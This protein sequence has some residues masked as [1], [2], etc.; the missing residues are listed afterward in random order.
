MIS[1]FSFRRWTTPGSLAATLVTLFPL[2]YFFPAVRGRITLCPD[3]GLLFN[4]PLRT[5]AAAIFLDGNLPLWNPYMFG[6]MPLFAS[7][8]GGLLFPLNWFYLIF[9][10]A[11]ATNM[12]VISTY[13]LAALGAYLYARRA[14]ASI[15]GA[16]VTSL[17]WQSGGVLV[18]QLSHINIVQ[19]AAMLP[20]LLWAMERYVFTRSSIR[21]LLLSVVVALQVFV[22]HP[23]TFCYSLLLVSAYAVVMAVTERSKR[24]GY[25]KSLAYI[26]AG[27]T[28]AAV[29][30]VP[31]LE[32]LRNSLRNEVT[33]DFF[34]SFSMPRR[35]IET[36]FAPYV[37]GGGDGGLFRAPYFGPPFYAEYI[38][39]VGLLTLMLALVALLIKRDSRNLFWTAIAVIGLILALGGNAP[40]GIAKLV[41]H[42]PVLNLFRVPSRHVMEVNFAL[43]VLAGRGLTILTSS[44]N[45][46]RLQAGVAGAAL[47]VFLLTCMAV[48]LGR[49]GEFR[50]GR[51]AP[52]T[53]LRAPELFVPVV[54]AALSAVALWIVMRGRMRGRTGVLITVL[55]IDL[56]IWGYSSGWRTNTGPAPGSEYWGQPETV[57][58]LK[59]RAQQQGQPNRILTLPHTFHPDRAPVPPSVSRST[60]WVVW[61]QPNIY[62]MH[63]IDNAAG[64]DGFGFARHSRLAGDMKV[65]GE[66]TDPNRTLRGSSREIDVLNVRYLLAIRPQ[67]KAP[68]VV[69][70][71][72][73]ATQNYGGNMFA[74]VDL[75]LSYLTSGHHVSFAVP[76]VEVDRIALVTNLAWAQDVPDGELLARVKLK[77][78]D[79]RVIE[80]PFRAG[81]DTAEWSYDR[82]DIRARVGHRRATIADSYAVKD[83]SQGE[84]NAHNYVTTLKLPERVKI[85]G[86]EIALEDFG[87]WPGLSLKLQRLT[88]AGGANWYPIRAEWIQVSA[89][90]TEAPAV[91][92]NDQLLAPVDNRW[93]LMGQTPWVDIYENTRALPRVW[94]APNE[95]VT[96]EDQAL[97]TIRTGQ[98][99]NGDSWDPLKTVLVETPTGIGSTN[100]ELGD[101]HA[102]VIR[103][104]VNR[105]AVK[106]RAGGATMLVLS[107]NHYPGWR[108]YVDQ[109]PADLIRANYN[110][111]GVRLEPGVHAVEFVYRPNSVIVGAVVSLLTL[112]GLVGLIFFPRGQ[113]FHEPT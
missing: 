49:P 91:E 76:P 78:S 31:T 6:G 63:R 88:M 45:T 50:L 64:Y 83:A 33:Y 32:L 2:F 75:S 16:I 73:P 30:I 43:A 111:R 38:A 108:V 71:F 113:P 21:G 103:R 18:A 13:M 14:G 9:N 105:V 79:G 65:W 86:G 95:I 29:Q 93:Q 102:E 70:S 81:I 35:F 48:T 67:S 46:R 11:A 59:A 61:T 92:S 89:V 8:Q 42:L 34:T 41:Y 22:G 47:L 68:T 5:T 10:A 1:T 58:F 74:G 99:P 20:W 17:V 54:L 85:S 80:L 27:I 7:A 60:D 101:N 26:A 107:E 40:L 39:Y 24:A 53:F 106:T 51:I 62:M 94:L 66:L 37:L 12:M 52:V 98:L 104:D 36:F 55:T 109:K 57:S 87:R 4:V 69:G 44:K 96:S 82:P 100:P 23:Q 3:D 90:Q 25:F 19:V 72:E 56:L 110:L 84:Y 77:S 28:L 112:L 15:A 97:E